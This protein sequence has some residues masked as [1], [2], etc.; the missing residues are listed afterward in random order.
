MNNGMELEDII[1]GMSKNGGMLGLSGV[2]K[3]MREIL[4]ASEDGNSRAGLSIDVFVCSIVRYIGSYYAEL[5]GLDHLVFT[6]GIGE[7]APEI[8]ARICSGL[9]HM[10][11]VLDG[12]K[13]RQADGASV[14]S[15][16]G[17]AVKIQIIPTN[18]E[19]DIAR[20][21]YD[22]ILNKN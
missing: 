17:S 6:G 5:G 20:K 2:D 22:A 3:D 12:S 4:Q 7:N 10:G 14:I 21:S 8:R 11:I 13:N 15:E 9:K 1:Y 19:I 18:E 16:E